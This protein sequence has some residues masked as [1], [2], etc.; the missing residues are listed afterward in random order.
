[1]TDAVSLPRYAVEQEVERPVIWNVMTIMWRHCNNNAS[2]GDF[3]ITND[4]VSSK[5]IATSLKTLLIEQSNGWWFATSWRSC[6]VTVM[7]MPQNAI[8]ILQMITSPVR[9][10]GCFLCYK[11][12][13]LL[14]KQSKGWGFETSWRSGCVTVI[15]MLQ[16]AISVLQMIISPIREFRCVFWSQSEQIVKRSEIW[17]AITL[18]WHHCKDMLQNTISQTADP[19]I[20]MGNLVSSLLIYYKYYLSS[21][22]EFGCFFCC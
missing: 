22:R 11:Q 21:K 15:T 20:G 8:S 13:R 16:N 4:Y 3:G 12:C 19:H 5:R 10:C 9:E 17:D 14:N 18:L 7:I 2:K 1:M 6:G